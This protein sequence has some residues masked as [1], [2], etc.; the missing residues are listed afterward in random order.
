MLVAVGL[1]LVCGLRLPSS[2]GW[3]ELVVIAFAASCAF[4]FGLFFA[5]AVFA[6]GSVL[7]EVKVGALSTIGAALI[8]IAAARMLAARRPKA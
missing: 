2:V 1:S 8:A 6:T 5:T 3:R 7:T 4:T